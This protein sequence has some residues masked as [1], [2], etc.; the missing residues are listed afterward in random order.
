M[1]ST[2][3]FIQGAHRCRTPRDAL[4]ELRCADGIFDF[5]VLDL[6][7]AINTIRRP[8]YGF[9]TF[10]PDGVAAMQAF[11][12]TALVD[13]LESKAYLRQYVVPSG[14]LGKK[15]LLLIGRNCLIGYILGCIGNRLPA[16]LYG[17]QHIAFQKGL[18]L[19]QLFFNGPCVLG[20]LCHELNSFIRIIVSLTFLARQILDAVSRKKDL[21]KGCIIEKF[22]CSHLHGLDGIAAA[23]YAKYSHVRRFSRD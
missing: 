5:A 6:F 15:Q 12:I 8:R 21:R 11:A 17:G 20:G 23:I 1:L 3:G 16:L 14:S 13:A 7:L 18:L 22:Q 10:G 19:A 9:E 2:K 4:H